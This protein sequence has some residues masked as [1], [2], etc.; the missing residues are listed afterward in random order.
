M[1]PS[2]PLCQ[3][4][5]ISTWNFQNYVI[6]SHHFTF[7]PMPLR[8]AYIRLELQTCGKAVLWGERVFESTRIEGELCLYTASVPHFLWY[9]S[10]FHS[11]YSSE[12]YYRLFEVLFSLFK[13]A[14]SSLCCRE[15][16]RR[17]LLWDHAPFLEKLRPLW[18]LKNLAL[19]K[20]CQVQRMSIGLH[21]S[22]THE[23]VR[24]FVQVI[25]GIKDVI[26]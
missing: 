5:G 25:R 22:I 19:N 20:L 13:C 1:L 24:G 3:V 18:P 12:P 7:S 4:S 10:F 17:A 6:Q 2:W 9:I 15:A 21:Q 11:F 14:D 26:V 23:F 16:P 8:D